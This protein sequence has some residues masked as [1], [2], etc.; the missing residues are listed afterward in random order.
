M[1]LNRLLSL[2]VACCLLLSA[3]VLSLQMFQGR[4]QDSARAQLDHI[5][6]VQSAI[7]V[8][9]SRL[10]LLQRY[11]DA[12]SL[13]ESQTASERLKQTLAFGV[14]IE[15]SQGAISNLQHMLSAVDRLLLLSEKNISGPNDLT[16]NS[17]QSL[18]SSR[19]NMLL[20]SMSEEVLVL[21]QRVQHHVQR[22]QEQIALGSSLVLALLSLS[23][24]VLVLIFRHRFR[25]GL[26]SLVEGIRKVRH[27]EL[28][29]LVEAKY[30][31]EMQE[32]AD[33]LSDMKFKLNDSMVS[34]DS[35]Q[36]EVE[37][38]TRQL[39][40]QHDALKRLA[41]TDSLTGLL[42][43]RA[44]ETQVKCA[45]ARAKRTG[46]RAALL[47]ID[48]NDFKLINDSYGHEAGDVLLT[49]IAT[50]LT[51]AVRATDLVARLGGDEFIVWLDL[52]DEDGKA[53]IAVKRIMALIDK[54]VSLDNQILQIKLS[55]G[56]AIYPNHSDSVEMLMKM[57]DESMYKAKAGK[58]QQSMTWHIPRFDDKD[59][60]DVSSVTPIRDKLPKA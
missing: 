44:F 25:G 38:Q 28:E 19:I 1:T 4:I 55:I 49:T 46:T 50:R 37:R 12:T 32:I 22:A 58:G 59:G 60:C 16:M 33:E 2:L 56:V 23:V 51:G 11:N 54:P 43:R 41:S 24:T 40:D 17:S 6:T 10:W 53:E 20:L 3:A 26:M 8:L 18:V 29:G 45:I 36:R 39:K 47:F 34:R 57:A 13:K 14:T 30:D 27:G 48:L 9:R 31:D 21:L 35:L 7:D 15:N 42:N 52:I 5:M